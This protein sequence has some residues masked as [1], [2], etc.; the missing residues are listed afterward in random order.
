MTKTS[1]PSLLPFLSLTLVLLGACQSSRSAPPRGPLAARALLDEL[2]QTEHAP[3]VQYAH[4]DRDG[5]VFEHAQGRA[6]LVQ[7]APVTPD[8]RFHGYSVTKT[9]TAA[10]VLLLAEKGQVELDAPISRYIG[11]LSVGQ[12]VPT[13]RQTLAHVGGWPNP[14]P[15]GWVHLAREHAHHDQAAFF[16]RLMKKHGELDSEP[17]E[18][19]SYSNV[20]YL[21]L[22]E[23]VRRVSGKPYE[24]YVE[25][26]L[27][28]PLAADVDAHLGFTFDA[29][30]GHA[31]GYV[32]H[33][34]FLGLAVGFFLDRER[35]MG[36][37]EGAWDPFVPLQVDGSAYGGLMGNA[38]GFA[39][40]LQAILRQEGQFSS[41]VVS[42]MFQTGRTGDGQPTPGA[43][44]WFRGEL[45]G[46]PY[47][48]HAGGGGGYYAEIR[49]YP[50]RGRASVLLMNRSGM[51]DDRL[52][53]RI[54]PPLLAAP[55]LGK[56]RG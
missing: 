23:L 18:T 39:R 52:L 45:T 56:P 20:G 26:E 40:Y 14:V 24:R 35:L 55:L 54:D 12:A 2:V 46:E 9:I 13:V 19:F 27:L 3:G 4:V 37:R 11:G 42:G 28:G 53:D 44:G 10:A 36:P 17:G 5:I 1:P 6:D 8:T 48:H 38:R 32:R 50:R 16:A 30:G 25:E 34:S 47:F 22:G 15:V 41:G 31:K 7:G 21:V 51:K 49:V 33:F 43:H 29:G